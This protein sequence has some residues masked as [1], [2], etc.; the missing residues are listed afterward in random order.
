[1]INGVYFRFSD[2]TLVEERSICKAALSRFNNYGS[3]K[4]G[5]RDDEVASKLIKDVIQTPSNQGFHGK[6]VGHIGHNTVVETPFKCHYGYNIHLG[7]KVHIGENCTFIDAC[8]VTIGPET[9]IGTNVTILTAGPHE[10]NIFRKGFDSTW[11]GKEVKIEREVIVGANVIIYPGVT[12]GLGCTIEP[13]AIVRED[14]PNGMI[15]A[16]LPTYLRKRGDKPKTE[17]DFV[18]RSS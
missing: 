11:Q 4:T 5:S 14:V 7:D 13:G 15:C 8:K 16:P 17:R 10:D 18:V 12:L 6:P 2:P 3:T 1:M 9:S